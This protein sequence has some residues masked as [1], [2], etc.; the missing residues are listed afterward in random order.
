M[1]LNIFFKKMIEFDKKLFNEGD[2]EYRVRYLADYMKIHMD[3]VAMSM[4]AQIMQDKEGITFDDAMQKCADFFESIR[5]KTP[6][7]KN[8]STEEILG[9][10]NWRYAFPRS[11]FTA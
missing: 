9:S 8:K 11:K 5:E 6:E 3:T 1:K 7:L 4:A 10:K 2:I